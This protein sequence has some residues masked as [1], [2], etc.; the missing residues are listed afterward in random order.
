VDGPAAPGAAVAAAHRHRVHR[1]HGRDVAEG[2]TNVNLPEAGVKRQVVTAARRT[3]V[4]ADGSK[5]GSVSLAPVCPIDDIDLH[6]TGPSA[7]VDELDRLEAQGL[8]VDVVEVA[9]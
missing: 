9:G 7:P 4:I 8:A 5:I 6:V 3:I 2:I 1:L